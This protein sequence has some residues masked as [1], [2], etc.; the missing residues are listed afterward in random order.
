[1]RAQLSR[2]AGRAVLKNESVDLQQVGQVKI[3]DNRATFKLGNADKTLEF[4]L[5]FLIHQSGT[6]DGFHAAPHMFGIV[7]M[8]AD[9]RLVDDFKGRGKRNAFKAG[10]VA[11]K[12]DGSM[13]IG[14][15]FIADALQLDSHFNLRPMGLNTP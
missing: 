6:I 14:G 15:F 10:A 7:N 8:T 9:K 2:Q 13:P 1:M 5:V 12:V 4:R 11:G 3:A